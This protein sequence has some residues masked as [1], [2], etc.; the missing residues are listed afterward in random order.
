MRAWR[1]LSKSAMWTGIAYPNLIAQKRPM[2]S[3]RLEANGREGKGTNEPYALRPFQ[4]WSRHPLSF[5]SIVSAPYLDEQCAL[6]LP[7]SGN[8]PKTSDSYPLQLT[9]EG[10]EV[11]LGHEAIACKRRRS[12]KKKKESPCILLQADRIPIKHASDSLWKVN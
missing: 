11:C 6:P 12:T 2:A 8:P 1:T 7:G 4:L 3:F 5:L 9:T 10:K